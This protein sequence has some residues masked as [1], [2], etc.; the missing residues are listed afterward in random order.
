MVIKFVHGSCFHMNYIV[1]KT[2]LNSVIQY[3]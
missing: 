3:K 2:F 1:C